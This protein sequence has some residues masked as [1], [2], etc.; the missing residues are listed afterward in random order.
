[1]HIWGGEGVGTAGCVGLPEERVAHLQEWTEGRHAVIAVV[2][3]DTVS[4]FGRCLPSPVGV[5]AH[6]GPAALP[7]P[8]PRREKRAGTRADLAR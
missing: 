3:E 7:L 2:S 5:S 4:R 8:N 1:M 6:K